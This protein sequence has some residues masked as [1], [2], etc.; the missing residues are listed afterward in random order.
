MKQIIITGGC[1]FIGSHISILLLEK[2]YKV[3]IIDNLYNSHKSIID[4]IKKIIPEKSNHLFFHYI[5]LCHYHDLLETFKKIGTVE[6]VIHC[7]GLKSVKESVSLPL[8]YYHT[9]LLSTLNLLNVMKEINCKTLLFSSSA[10]VYGKAKPP[11]SET[12]NTGVG[13]TNPYGKTKFMI[14]EILKDEYH[15]SNGW[16]MVL[17]RYFN[18][19]GAHPSGM[20]GENPNGIPNNL[21]PYVMKVAGKE[22]EK[23]TVYGKDYET[24]DGTGVRD[25]IHIMDLAEGHISALEYIV[26]KTEKFEIFN[27]GSGI[28]T[29]VLEMIDTMKEVSGQEI[30]FEYGSRRPGDL[31]IVYCN[32][33]KANRLLKWK[34]EKTIYDM[35][36]DLWNYFSLSRKIE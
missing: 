36:R 21:M 22:L 23:I 5:D 6:G 35:C 13:L 10:T 32:P 9:N 14:E 17:L 29:S 12:T 8:L 4:N 31:P 30:L 16:K 1:G 20:I 18:P 25:Y 28:G 19:V 15:A 34:T 7:A 3:H 27:L 11:L 33:S 24:S 2:G 26:N